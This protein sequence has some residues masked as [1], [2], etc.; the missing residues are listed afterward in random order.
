MNNKTN[1]TTLYDVAKQVKRAK[2]I[3]NIKGVLLSC[4]VF[5]FLAFSIK[6]VAA[7][8]VSKTAISFGNKVNNINEF[9]RKRIISSHKHPVL[10]D[11]MIGKTLNKSRNDVI[12][13]KKQQAL[14]A[15]SGSKANNVSAI[16]KS[17]S[18][19]ATY[20][21]PEFSIYDAVSYLEEDYDADGYYR[22]FSVVFDAD[23]Y[24]PNGIQDSVIYAEL[25]ISTDGEN[26]THYYTTDDFLIHADT[27]DDQYEVITTFTQGYNPDHYD[28]LI[29]IYEVGYSDIVATYSSYDNNA[30]YALPLESAD[31]DQ[32]YVDEVVVHGGSSSIFFLLSMGFIALI[33][34][35]KR[36]KA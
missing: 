7:E 31:Y 1:E 22:T 19:Y 32:V 28:I 14:T 34:V 27:D 9:A 26:W 35:A 16:K 29:D 36:M 24:N 11:Q 8:E 6:N 3:N 33:R 13:E 21:A 4:I 23:V 17:Y 18:P 12:I 5:G 30:L 20:Y 10:S 2:R 15:L 25:Y